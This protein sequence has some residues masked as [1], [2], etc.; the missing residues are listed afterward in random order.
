MVKKRASIRISLVIVIILAV[1]AVS[2]FALWHTTANSSG[3]SQKLQVVAAENFW[4]NI[5]SQIGGNHVEITSII[6]NPSA[7]PHLYESNARDAAALSNARI[8]IKNGL[9]YDDFMD[10]LMAASPH[11][12]RQVLSIDKVLN[13]VGD[14]PNPHLWYDIPHVPEVADAIEQAME[15]KDPS[16]S[17]E[18]A[19]N[20]VAFKN[21]LQP[22]LDTI[23]QIKDKYPGAP[24]AYTERVPGYLLGA[25]GLNVKTPLG[26]ASA[27]EDGNDPSPQ[28]TATMESL[29]TNHGIR[30][31]LYNAQ[32]TS[33]V[34]Q[35]IRDLAHQNGIPIVGV[36]ETLP[37]TEQNYQSWQLDQT[38]AL[39]KALGG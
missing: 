10:K 17:S 33:V 28:D 24:V 22:V 15:A 18:Y 13:P 31:L 34:T 9:G 26:F 12:G 8:V 35:H 16:H 20:L 32:A 29:M 27:I 14:N 4:G 19:V 11:S 38:K 5:T 1:V 3:D 36:T 37:P 6:T 7:D 30:V 21:S 23:N 39:L 2:V 25:A